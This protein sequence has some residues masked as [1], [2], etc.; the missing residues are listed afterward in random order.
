MKYI[1]T[2]LPSDQWQEFNR[3]QEFDSEEKACQHLLKYI[4]KDCQLGTPN[5]EDPWLYEPTPDP[6]NIWEL[7]GTPCGC[8]WDYEI[9][10]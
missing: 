5:E 7:L 6:E 8:E 4:C 10:E 9:S 1:L 2:Y 3:S